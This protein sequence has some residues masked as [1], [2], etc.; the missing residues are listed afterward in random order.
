QAVASILAKSERWKYSDLRE[1]HIK[2]YKKD[3]NKVNLK[4]A[5]ADEKSGVPTD[6]RIANFYQNPGQDNGLA[7]LYY[8]YGRYLTLSST[9]PH[10]E[11]ALPPNLQRL[12]AHQ[13]QTP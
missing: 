3:F 2:A 4:I 13:V 10:V 5:D 1:K 8:Q 12:W 9:A 6:K 11:H 7:V